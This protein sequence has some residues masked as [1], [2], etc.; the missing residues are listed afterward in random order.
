MQYG[1]YRC[2]GSGPFPSKKNTA[3]NRTVYDP[4]RPLASNPA[5]WRRNSRSDFVLLVHDMLAHHWIILLDLDLAG[6][7]ALVFKGRVKMACAGRGDQA[8]LLSHLGRHGNLLTTAFMPVLPA[9][10][11]MLANPLTGQTKAPNRGQGK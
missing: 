3:P 7:F 8:N 5:P 9:S 2:N 6:G 1:V 4:R 10:P 11:N